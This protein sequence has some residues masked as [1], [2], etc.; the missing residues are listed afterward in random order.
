MKTHSTKGF[1]L[2]ELLG[3]VA[4]IA[5][6]ATVSITSISGAIQGGREAA[7]K[8]QIQ[9]LNSAYQ[10]YLAAGGVTTTSDAQ[11]AINTLTSAVQLPN[12]TQTV[13]PFLLSAPNATVLDKNGASKAVTFAVNT[14]FAAPGAY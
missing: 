8:R 11:V 2:V 10:N 3:V 6:L 13:G 7:A 1:T 4:I 12:S 14:G 5:V 9:T